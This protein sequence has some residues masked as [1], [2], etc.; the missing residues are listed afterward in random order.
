MSSP[1][2][3]I[4]ALVLNQYA[5]AYVLLMLIVFGVT[6]VGTRFFLEI[7]GYPQIG[8]KTFHIAHALWGGLLLVISVVLMLVFVNHRVFAL[9]AVLA[10]AGVGLF[11]DEVGKFIT[12]DLDYFFPLAAPVI[13]VSFLISVLVYLSIRRRKAI[14][15]RAEMYAILEAWQ[16]LL[17]NDL[18]TEVRAALID[19]LR[20][21]SGQSDR[22]DLAVLARSLLDYVQSDVV[23]VV[24]DR[25]S[26]DE[27]A[28]DALNRLGERLLPQRN[29][30]RALIIIFGALTG[31]SVLRIILLIVLIFDPKAL[32]EL[33]VALV[34]SAQITG[35]TS[36]FSYSL[37][38]AFETI[39]G[40]LF[41]AA[42]AL[43]L[44]KHDAAALRLGLIGLIVSLTATNVLSFYFYQFSIVSSALLQLVILFLVQR[45][46]NGLAPREAPAQ[47]TPA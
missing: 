21:V 27:R 30:R 8:D 20:R 6:V 4:R 43:L 38:L 40:C 44:G 1:P 24:Q 39:A 23:W 7:T 9:A 32:H 15:A 19:R 2:R 35:S 28:L 41:V 26:W 18:E 17:V 46:R 12:Q 37:M 34:N 11:I 14:G 42:F 36:L 25:S 33:V 13:Y 31:F 10:G 22:A 3:R 5:P 29:L 45:Y 47:G 16:E